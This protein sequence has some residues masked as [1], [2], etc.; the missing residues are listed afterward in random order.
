[1]TRAEQVFSELSRAAAAGRD[2]EEATALVHRL[3]RF[4]RQPVEQ[5]LV[6]CAQAMADEGE[7]TTL[8]RVEQ[9]LEGVLAAGLWR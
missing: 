4:D 3:V 5:A 2:L 1:V 8:R 7:T 6:L 9:L